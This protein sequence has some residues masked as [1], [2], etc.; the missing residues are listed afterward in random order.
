MVSMPD[1]PI[2]ALAGA[3][4]I[5]LVGLVVSVRGI[6]KLPA[7]LREVRLWDSMR[8]RENRLTKRS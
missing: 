8:R 6:G 5:L 4:P 7:V 3:H 2:V 1:I